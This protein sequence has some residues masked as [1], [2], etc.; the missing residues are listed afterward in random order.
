M[1][2]E[3]GRSGPADRS[4]AG[5]LIA[6][7]EEHGEIVLTVARDK[8]V[9]ALTI[10]RDAEGYQQLMEMA[11]VDYP[12]RVE[13]FEVVYMLLSLTANHRILVKVRAGEHTPVPP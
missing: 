2:L 6:A 13:R 3:R 8:I 12:D 9:E 10:L 11:G 4:L 5:L 1:V 7:R